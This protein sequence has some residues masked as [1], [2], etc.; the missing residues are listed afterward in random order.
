[1][2]G[3]LFTDDT[4]T[5]CSEVLEERSSDVGE[6]DLSVA[7]VLE[8]MGANEARILVDVMQVGVAVNPL[9]KLGKQAGDS[10]HNTRANEVVE[11]VLGDHFAGDSHEEVVGGTRDF[12]EP[13]GTLLADVGLEAFSRVRRAEELTSL[14]TMVVLELA[15]QFEGAIH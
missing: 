10:I 15:N 4:S 8:V 2:G 3:H 13:R 9:V 7:K 5:I 1:M 6:V 14:V 12:R 11:V